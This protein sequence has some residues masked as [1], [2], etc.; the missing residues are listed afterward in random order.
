M[1]LIIVL[2]SLFTFSFGAFAADTLS[3]SISKATVFLSGAQVFRESKSISVKRGVNEYIIKDVSPMLDQQ[4]IQATSKGGFLILDVQF[5]TEYVQP[6]SASPTIVP[7]KI[8]KEIDWLNDTLLFISFEKERI[9]AKLNDLQEEKRMVTQSQLIKSG[10]I[11]DTLPEFKEIVAFYRTKLDDINEL[12]HQWKKTQYY[13]SARENKFR[14]R[15]NEL[16]NYARQTNQPVQPAT[17]RYHVLVTTY[18]DATTTGKIEINYL[19]NNAGWIPEYDLR[20]TSTAEPMNITYKARVFQN[21]GEDW[22]K[23]NLVL[24]TYDRNASI[25]K[26]TAGIWRLDY[27]V[28][29]VVPGRQIQYYSQNFAS[30]TQME[31]FAEKEAAQNPNFTQTGASYVPYQNLSALNQNFT[32]VEFDVKLPY[33]I[34]SDGSQK[35]MVVMHE[36]MEAKFYHYMLPRANKYAF[37]QAK[38]GDWEELSLLPGKA[39]IYFNHTIVGSLNIDPSALSDT[40]E[41]TLG[42]D[43]SITAERK[44]IAEIDEKVGIGKRTVKKMTFQLTIRNNSHGEIDLTLEDLVPITQNEEIEIK[45]LKGSGAELNEDTGRLTWKLKMKPGQKELINFSY[46]VEHDKDKPVS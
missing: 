20:A 32:N 36:K 14:N 1:K 2:V 43:Q 44:K 26:P 41:L 18:A 27:T 33:S 45:V 28:N 3:T 30:N 31:E 19:V 6:Q 39:N 23:V 46:S 37:L 16:N 38:I 4:R 24:S 15:L 9:S 8:Q 35:L 13:V 12:I 7:E 21:T 29:K 17:T 40:M 42:R 11:S 10:G 22:D 34:S 5:L 25:S